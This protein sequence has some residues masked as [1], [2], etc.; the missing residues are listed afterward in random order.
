MNI[1]I[2]VIFFLKKYCAVEFVRL[3]L[4]G[5]LK[6]RKEEF[7]GDIKHFIAIESAAGFEEVGQRTFQLVVS[8]EYIDM[9]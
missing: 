4:L 1:V 7:C 8:K 9:F 2:G 5:F 6:C 3:G